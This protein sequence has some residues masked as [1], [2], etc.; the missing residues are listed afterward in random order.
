MVAHK[1]LFSRSTIIGKC[2]ITNGVAHMEK[3]RDLQ[4]F[5][6]SLNVK[7]AVVQVKLGE[8]DQEAWNRHL[9]DNPDD[10]SAMLKI[11]NQLVPEPAAAGS[12]S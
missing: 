5:S 1:K 3:F 12:P 9:K 8:S 11:F 6:D 2:E 4:E 10:A 7:M